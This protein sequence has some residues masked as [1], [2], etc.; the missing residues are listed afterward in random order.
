MNRAMPWM[1]L[2]KAQESSS[3]WL[4]GLSMWRGVLAA[5]L[6]IMAGAGTVAGAQSATE[7]RTPA[8]P[9]YLGFDRNDYPGDAALPLLRKTFRYAGYWLNHPPGEAANGWTGKRAILQKNGFGFLVLFTGRTFAEIK[10]A[11]YDAREQ[12]L[13]D[14]KKAVEAANREGF[15]KNVLIFL[16]QEEG[17]RLLPEQVA[18]L[19]GWV[20]AVRDGGARPG[21]YCSAIEVKDSNG[22]VSTALDI[23]GIERDRDEKRAGSATGG[24]DG[25]G[26]R[27]ALWIVNDPCPPAPACTTAA[28]PL[29]QGVADD[30][31]GLV[32]VWQYALSP[33]RAKLSAGCPQNQAPDGNCYAPG[34]PA[35]MRIFV[36]LDVADSP[37]PSEDGN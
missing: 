11:R 19:F 30:L 32:T 36:D 3:R 33:R 16:D 10:A 34:L 6:A 9:A 12:G 28:P 29:E 4:T 20:D 13:Q 7:T 37:D 15:Q 2:E 25:T 35:G 26:A 5:G 27:L 22:T 21:V 31:R 18:Y 1:L 8:S 24:V 23:A 14:G 17:G